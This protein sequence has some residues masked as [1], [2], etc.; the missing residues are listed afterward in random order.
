MANNA[1]EPKSPTQQAHPGESKETVLSQPKDQPGDGA[2][3]NAPEDLA[4]QHSETLPIARYPAHKRSLLAHLDEREAL[5]RDVAAYFRTQS[6]K[7]PLSYAGE[8]MLDNSYLVQQSL[9]QIREDL[10]P[11][12]YRQLP[13]LVEGPLE[14]YPRIYAIAQELVVSSGAHLDIDRVRRFV[15]LYQDI[16]PLSMGE[17]WALPAMLRLGILEYLAQALG[18]I[19]G[20]HRANPLPTMVL[21]RAVSDD[22]IVANCI[23]SLRLL[24]TQD[25]QVFF[26][27]VSRVEQVLRGDPV[28]VYARMDPETRDRYRKV[29]EELAR[30]TRRDEEQV[31]RAAIELARR[32][33]A[34]P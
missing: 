11:G 21:P 20:M 3:R 29:I 12:F 17:L 30:A 32:H 4:R 26:E 31:A 14:D 34:T 7:E 6:T 16:T 33:S 9:R 27:S 15:H 2:G 13:T 5:F 23:T 28:K 22:E 18:R 24:E 19:T 10:P 1:V 8:W 25:W